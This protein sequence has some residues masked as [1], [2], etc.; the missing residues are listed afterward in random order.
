M[1]LLLAI[2]VIVLVIRW[3]VIRSRFNQMNAKLDQLVS[4]QERVKQLDAAM[5][6]AFPSAATAEGQEAPEV[7]AEPSVPADQ[8]LPGAIPAQERATEP[9]L[10]DQAPAQP[11]HDEHEEVTV[12]A[13]TVDQQVAA[14]RRVKPKGPSALAKWGQR[15]REQFDQEE[16]EA[17]VGGNWLNKLGVLVLVIGI[18]LFLGYSF[19]YLGPQGRVAVGFAVSLTVLLGGIALER[20]ARYRLFA[21]GLIGGGW[22]A[23]YFTT[24]AMHGLEAARVIHDPLIAMVLLAIVA[25]I[26]IAHSLRYRSETV[27]GLAYVVGFVTLAISPLS[28]FSLAASVPLVLTLLFLAHRFSWS[29][30]AFAAVIFTY[31]TYA[32]RLGTW[33]TTDATI[34]DFLVG[35]LALSFYW[36]SFEAFDLLSLRRRDGQ[37]TI[38]RGIFPLNA[39]GFFGVSLLQWPAAAPIAVHV[40]LAATA[41]VYFL[42]TLV[43]ARVR[44]PSSFPTATATLRRALLGGYEASVTLA[45]FLAIV[46]IMLGFS[47]LKMNLALLVE[48]EF[49]FLA[50]LSLRQQYLRMLAG[51]IFILAVLVLLTSQVVQGGDTTLLGTTIKAWTPLALLMTVVFYLNRG[52]LRSESEPQRLWANHAYS[53]V[54]SAILVLVLGFEISAEYLGIAWLM[55]ALPLFELAVRRGVDEFRYQSYAIV[56]LAWS[57]LAIV[58]VLGLVPYSA[59]PWLPLGIAAALTCGLAIRLTRLAPGQLPTRERRPVEYVSSGAT[60]VL[61]AALLWYVLP[62]P[63]V[64]VGWGVLGLLW[65]EIGL[66]KPLPFLRVQ[67]HVVVFAAVGYLFLAN[68]TNLGETAGL[69]HRVLTVV[70]LIALCYYL[71]LRLV[72][73]DKHMRPTKWELEL[74][75]VYLYAAPTLAVILIRFE[76]GRV[77][78]VLGWALLTV[79]LLFFGIRRDNRDLRWQSYLLAMLTFARSWATNFYIPESLAGIFGRVVTGGIVVASLYVAQFLSPRR[80][81]T[82]GPGEGNWLRRVLE[83]FDTNGRTVFSILATV[84]LTVLLFYEVSGSVLTVAWGLESLVL[85]AVGF[86]LAERTLRLSGLVLLLV[87]T[88]KL[89]AYD[90]RELDALYRIISFGALGLLLLGISWLYTRFREKIS[91]Y[92]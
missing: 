22:A 7:E 57:A 51:L 81:A 11:P 61:L 89:F 29:S 47:G 4:L 17:V 82:Q 18:A 67:G 10:A 53:Y 48:G 52:L 75:R 35:Q 45:A 34:T 50:G 60:T 13:E 68:F 92:I 83:R 65:I 66:S 14:Y 16:W 49:L 1:E 56:A 40:F 72:A 88:L 12:P 2:L 69:S 63:V 37:L 62:P 55:F 8:S 5:T 32:V 33:A 70:P 86:A 90:V 77:A 43:R 42:S 87:C 54:A 80:Q 20:R 36:L 85:L 26:M 73:D 23:V 59:Q 21:W 78:A 9:L 39:C 31:G 25:A 91:R 15:L 6:K 24:Y 74:P 71:W 28:G 41:A 84:L 3:A 79:G 27:T 64:A 19:A 76:F 46:T 44:S 30:M 38:A 58:N